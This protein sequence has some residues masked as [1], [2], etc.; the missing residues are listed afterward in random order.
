MGISTRAAGWA[1]ALT[2][3]FTLTGCSPT[4]A[5]EPAELTDEQ[6]Y[7]LA[8]ETYRQYLEIFALLTNDP[9]QPETL[10]SQVESGE[11]LEG[12]LAGYRDLQSRG[13]RW[14]GRPEIVGVQGVDVLRLGSA[15]LQARI[16][17]CLDYSTVQ[18]VDA[19]GK[20]M[21][22]RPSDPRVNRRVTV[23]VD[24][25]GEPKVMRNVLEGGVCALA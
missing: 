6:A 17:L 24:R 23:Q 1:A 7:A 9:S 8:E 20:Q 3:A 25:D 13:V 21:P 16:D 2:L 5:E 14:I 22:L 10:L 11:A 12:D 19:E 4:G 15:G 18:K